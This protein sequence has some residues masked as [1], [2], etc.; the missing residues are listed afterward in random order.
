MTEQPIEDRSLSRLE[1]LNSALASGTLGP[2]QQLLNTLH[3]AEIARLLESLPRTQRY[4]IWQLIHPDEQGDIL[5][6]VNDEVRTGLIGEM[7]TD[8]LLAAATSMDM[9]DLADVF[10]DLPETVTRQ[11]LT[12][13]DEQDRHRLDIV[14]SYSEDSAGGL[15]NT[16]TV[17]VRP[18]VSLDVVLR[19]LRMKKELPELT[20]SL[21]VVGDNDTLI[22]TLPLTSIITADPSLKVREVMD[23]SRHAVLASTPAVEVAEQFELHDLISAPVV[24]ESNK[25]LGRITIDD[26][27]DVIRDEADQD[28]MRL[29]GLDEEDDMFAPIIPSASRR[30]IW[31]GINLFTA[32]LAS[33]V[34]GL[35]EA[36]LDKFV[37]LAVLMP[38]VASMGGVA[39]SQT[40]TLVIRAM[41]LGQLA[42]SNT[43]WLLF[44]EVAVGALNG[45]LWACVVAIVAY[46]WFGDKNIG[47]IIAAAMI[48]NLVVATFTGVSLPLLL[49]RIGIDPALAG[50]VLLT[51]ITDIVGFM[52]FLGLATWWLL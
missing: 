37:A 6:H 26:V 22:G 13:M 30:A 40:L 8:E 41:A 25:L 46:L 35:F 44:K 48:I 33:W 20:D 50:S 34:I 28:L 17:T 14:R 39:G 18:D 4:I 10:D 12:S 38:I 51:T 31:L 9:D 23:S 21:S 45:I 5:S 7:E 29:A 27:V 49:K 2:I 43:R 24:D 52:A 42:K 15:M 19:Y 16:D 47:L 3:P 32:L 1:D 36:T 11:L